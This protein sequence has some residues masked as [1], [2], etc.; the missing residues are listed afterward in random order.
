M[1]SR[2]VPF[3]VRWKK[4]YLQTLQARTKWSDKKR[5]FEIGDVVLLKDEDS[6]RNS[7]PRAVVVNTFPGDDGLVRTV[8]VKIASGSILKRPIVKIVLLVEACSKQG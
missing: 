6:V 2:P 7:W 3:W 8:E 4:E 5:N 1:E